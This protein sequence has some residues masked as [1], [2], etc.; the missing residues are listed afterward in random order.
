MTRVLLQTETKVAGAMLAWTQRWTEV[1][2]WEREM[3][4]LALT[5]S[6]GATTAVA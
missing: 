3:M 4:R 6:L 2:E 1:V 5:G